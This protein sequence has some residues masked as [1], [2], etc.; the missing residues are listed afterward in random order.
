[1][2][3]G[4]CLV[5]GFVAY[6]SQTLLPAAFLIVLVACSHKSVSSMFIADLT[7]EDQ[8]KHLR[9]RSQAAFFFAVRSFFTVRIFR[10]GWYQK[11]DIFQGAVRAHD[12]GVAG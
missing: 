10:V 7:V 6:H 3:L 5:G 1:M 2:Q 9:P 12:P 8:V 11:C 4:V